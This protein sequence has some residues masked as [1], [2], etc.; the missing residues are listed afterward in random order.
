[1][2]HCMPAQDKPPQKRPDADAIDQEVVVAD[3]S[4]PDYTAWKEKDE[5]LDRYLQELKKGGNEKSP[6]YRIVSYIDYK[7]HDLEKRHK[8]DY[9][10][11]LKAVTVGARMGAD[12]Q[13][14]SEIEKGIDARSGDPRK[15]LEERRTVSLDLDR[16]MRDQMPPAIHRDVM[17]SL[18]PPLRELH[19]DMNKHADNYKGSDPGAPSFNFSGDNDLKNGDPQAA[20]DDFS[21][22]LEYDPRSEKALSGRAMANYQLGQYQAA[23]NDA[24]SAL[25][26]NPD[27]KAAIGVEKLS[28]G[29][30][31]AADDGAALAQ[32]RQDQL[33]VGGGPRDAAVAGVAASAQTTR[34]AANSLGLGDFNGAI[35]Q[36]DR[37]ISQNP[38]NA[39]A[40]NFR[41]I[42][43]NGLGQYDEAL[44]DS[45][46]GLRLAPNS[47]ALLNT[48]AYTLNRVKNYAGAL[49]AADAALKINPNDASAH[50]N[51]AYALRGLGDRE[52]MLAEIRKAAALDPRFQS[53]LD[54]ALQM[55]A[56]SDVFFLFP[57]EKRPAAQA[58]G[59]SPTAQD[60]RNRFLALGLASLVLGSVLFFLVY[61]KIARKPEAKAGIIAAST[62]GLLGGQ[63]KILGQI[64]AGG[65]GM[66]FE[67]TDRSLD[68]R[69]A[70]KKMRPELA[71]DRRERERFVGE[72][73]TVAALHHPNIVDIYAVVEEGTDVY[74]IFEHVAGKTVFDL[75]AERGPMNL[76]QASVIIKAMGEALE[77][78]HG[79]GVIHRDLKTPNVMIDGENRVKVMDFGI[80]HLAKEAVTRYAMTNTVLG[81]PL[82]M[83]PEQEQGVVCRESDIYALAICFYEMLAGR[84][85]FMGSGANILMNKMN[86][87]YP[88][89]SSLVPG[90]PKGIDE[91][92]AKALAPNPKERIS[93]AREFVDGVG[94][95]RA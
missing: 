49:E 11:L 34:E 68:R 69:V 84:T 44:K 29:R 4:N 41:A 59:S 56:D 7:I 25:Q 86:R 70:I 94:S 10:L 14:L 2:G 6:I 32:A 57:G 95:F 47:L 5:A 53:S 78:A 67:G 13:R 54:S 15:L 72:A 43:R 65:M 37:A 33:P 79:K 92:F 63:Y 82:Y 9:K 75:L 3:P 87:A 81:T 64:G 19:F 45:I 17:D 85:P 18:G 88:P 12:S 30:G 1:M 40:F 35:S 58:S 24:R 62:P 31:A 46:A 8:T 55:P 93:S 74:L 89:I 51:R 73:R 77:F 23:F 90:L 26:I 42:A 27:D 52:G 66:V 60:R 20:R 16:L 76:A 83:A 28:E 71:S 36:L 50:A 48:R 80:A 61:P 39:Q 38:R 91:F 22:A 21:K